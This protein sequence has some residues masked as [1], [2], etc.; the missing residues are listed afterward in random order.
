MSAMELDTD[1]STVLATLRLESESEEVMNILY[2]LEDYYE[3]KLWHQLTLSLE[4]FYYNIPEVDN[5]LKLKIYKFF[6]NQFAN[7]L[8]TIK[9]VDFLLISFSSS[10]P[11]QTLD[12]LVE[13]K[14]RVT[15]D[16]KK[17]LSLQKQDDSAVENDESIIYINL[18]IARYHLLLNDITMA[19]EIIE[20]LSLKFDSNS[21]NSYDNKVNAAY[22]FTKYEFYKYKQN[23][24]LYYSNGLLYLSS[25][26]DLSQEEQVGLC[27]DLCLATL[28]GDQIYNFGE[29]ILHRILD[30]IKDNE[31][32]W[33]YNLVH[34]LN[35]GNLHEFNKWLAIA[36]EK[37]PQLKQSDLFLKQKIMIMS[38]LELVSLQ[39]TTNKILSFTQISEFTGAPLNDVEHLII[40]CFSLKLIKGHINQID[41]TLVVSWLQPRVLNLDQIKVLYNHLTHWD[42]QVDKLA[43]EVHTNGGSIWAGL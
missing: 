42:Q 41:E 28:L 23:Y 6:I 12:E 38:L 34:T 10:N 2:Q 29:L 27:Y 20:K 4:E 11:Q 16:L 24:N 43:K 36:Y 13:L 8:N 39:S 26:K 15:K 25:V 7:N 21:T 19:D 31:Y 35:S 5:N 30:S 18:H 3:R 1:I 14:L 17:E 32:A 22:Y 40:K 33:L 37:A 9:V